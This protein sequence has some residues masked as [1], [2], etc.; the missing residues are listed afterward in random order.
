MQTYC[1]SSHLEG[2]KK[3]KE[4]CHPSL[5]EASAPFSPLTPKFQDLILLTVISSSLSVSFYLIFFLNLVVNFN[6]LILSAVFKKIIFLSFSKLCT[7]TALFKMD[8]QQG[9]TV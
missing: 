2:K 3:K 8:N 4:S 9:P 6:F 7:Y 5:M 1:N